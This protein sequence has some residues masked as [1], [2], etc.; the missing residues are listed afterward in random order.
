M[1]YLPFTI[2]AYILNSIAVTVDKL[3]ITKKIPDPLVYVLYFSVVSLIALLFIPFVA[4]PNFLVLLIAST[5][6]LLW[7]SGAYFMFHG[8]KIGQVSRVIPV[9]GTLIPVFL[10]LQGIFSSSLVQSQIIAIIFLISG[11]IFLT[12]FDWKGKI[13]KKE[14]MFEVLS[15][16]FFA[17]SYIVLKE[18]YLRANFL[19][20]LVY[21]R[22]ILIPVGLMLIIIPASRKIIFPEKK[23]ENSEKISFWKSFFKSKTPLIFAV[24]QFCGGI[25]ELLLTFSV[26]LASPALVN[27]L[28]G[29]QYVFLFILN[30]FLSKKNP[31]VFKENLTVKIM[32]VKFLGI[33][34]IGF[35]LYLLASGPKNLY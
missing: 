15:A 4:P 6:T 20:V 25:S 10:L 17:V 9:I 8:L 14:I 30:L 21:S 28:Q 29:V 5:S 33:I 1:N 22:P 23:Q 32:A 16:L 19:T 13:E 35:G 2:T 31:E 34:S 26:S 27:S 3:L 11:L 12:I 18:A 24:G 7:T